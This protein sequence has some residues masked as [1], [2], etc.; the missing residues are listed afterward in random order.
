MDDLCRC[1]R[2]RPV[3]IRENEKGGYRDAHAKKWAVPLS[4][5]ETALLMNFQKLHFITSF[6]LFCYIIKTSSL[7]PVSERTFTLHSQ[8]LSSG[9]LRS[10][11]I[12]ISMLIFEFFPPLNHSSSAFRSILRSWNYNFCN[13]LCGFTISIYSLE[14]ILFREPSTGSPGK[15]SLLW[16]FC[17]IFCQELFKGKKR[18]NFRFGKISCC[19]LYN[20]DISSLCQALFDNNL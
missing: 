17:S 9:F 19:Y 4:R 20:T 14:F 5:H 10:S 15:V 8:I 6:S 16:S 1:F 3:Q 13:L 2:F 11:R 12:R 7:A 18:G